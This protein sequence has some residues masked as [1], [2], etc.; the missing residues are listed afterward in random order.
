MQGGYLSDVNTEDIEHDHDV[1]QLEVSESGKQP[2]YYFGDSGPGGMPVLQK[3]D[4][5][6]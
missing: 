6:D 3:I 4:L 5:V 1:P 2:L